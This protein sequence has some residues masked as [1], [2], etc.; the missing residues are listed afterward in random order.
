[1]TV[2][3]GKIAPYQ[4]FCLLFLG[5]VLSTTLYAPSGV[6]VTGALDAAFGMTCAFFLQLFVLVPMFFLLRKNTGEDFS[7]VL[8]NQL[9]IIGKGIVL[10]YVI[11]CLLTA[12]AVTSE[13]AYFMSNFTRGYDVIV[14]LAV[15]CIFAIYVAKFGLQAVARVGFLLFIVLLPVTVLLF[16]GELLCADFF[17]IRPFLSDSLLKASGGFLYYS[18][19]NLELTLL[20]V[21]APVI[22]S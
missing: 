12:T 17:R 15:V 6:G 14:Y 21:L 20:P 22:V 7:S 11:Y 18:F 10:V 8:Q 9:G 16:S 19:S 1:M 4:L 5:R 2:I 3:K 13:I